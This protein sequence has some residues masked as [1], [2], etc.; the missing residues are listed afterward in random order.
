MIY[1]EQHLVIVVNRYYS[2]YPWFQ[3]LCP[4]LCWFQ[5]LCPWLCWCR[6]KGVGRAVIDFG[7]CSL[8]FAG[9]PS[10]S[11][12]TWHEQRSISISTRYWRFGHC[13]LVFAGRP[14][15]ACLT[16][17]QQSLV[18]CKILSL[19]TQ[20]CLRRVVCIVPSC[21]EI[22]PVADSPTLVPAVRPVQVHPVF[23]VIDC[24]THRR[25]HNTTSLIWTLN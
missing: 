25:C 7:P 14:C 19:R 3:K 2:L 5:K 23:S 16:W 18:L 13:S 12:W 11:C 8:V 6:E 17:H 15:L 1:N 4:W 21:Q 20:S 24:K 10:L 9:R 22:A